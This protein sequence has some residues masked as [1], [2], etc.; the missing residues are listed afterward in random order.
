MI[1]EANRSRKAR[2]LAMILIVGV[3]L[4]GAVSGLAASRFLPTR[5]AGAAVLTGERAAPGTPAETAGRGGQPRRSMAIMLQRRLELSE[6]QRA[7]IEQI[8]TARRAKTEMVL[9]D[10]EPRIQAQRDST[11]LEIR[12]ILTPE[13]QAAFEEM[14]AARPALPSGFRDPAPA[15]RR[16][17]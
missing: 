17:R 6:A 12:A 7:Q 15:T 16:D 10:V 4:A 2:L 1:G 5:D 11:D 14:V 8:F 13:Q 9:Q 3:F